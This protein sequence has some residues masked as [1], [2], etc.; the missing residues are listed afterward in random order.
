MNKLDEDLK[1]YFKENPIPQLDEQSLAELRQQVANN[2]RNKAKVRQKW[3]T[4]M[5]TCLVVLLVPAILLP[6]LLRPV[7]YYKDTDV[8]QTEVTATFAQEYVNTNYSQ[9]NFV[10]EECEL[11]YS[12]GIYSA[13]KNELLSLNLEFFK[14]EVPFSTL[15]LDIIVNKNLELNKYE[16][17]KTDS[18]KTQTQEYVLYK[19]E[20]EKYNLIT[21]SGLV[22]FKTYSIF[23]E[24][25]ESDLDYFNKF[26]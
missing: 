20:S 11:T 9:Y 25:N 23:I 10:F 16:L 7:K 24:I 15:K 14:L 13:D 26:L 12:Y 22:E 6:I 19:K 2:K 5:A 8:T 18:T 21:Y 1:S 4:L 17:I 3:I